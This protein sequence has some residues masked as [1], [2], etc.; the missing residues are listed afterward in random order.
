MQTEAGTGMMQLKAE[1][2]GAARSRAKEG[3]L[4]DSSRQPFGPPGSPVVRGPL[5]GA[6]CC[7]AFRESTARETWIS[8]FQ[9]PE[10]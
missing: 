8:D 3:F 2:A 1:E 7:R 10:R 5:V 4:Q 9:A 6:C